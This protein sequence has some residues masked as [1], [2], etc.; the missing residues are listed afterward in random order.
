V[1]SRNGSTLVETLFTLV[2]GT[3]IFSVILSLLWSAARMYKS[4]LEIANGRRAAILF[5]EQLESD[6][7][8]CTVPPGRRKDPVAISPD[9]TRL[10]FFRAD[11]ARSTLQ[12]TI[13]TPVEYGLAGD[14][15]PF[16]PVRNGDVRASV[17]VDHVRYELVR[18]DKEAKRLSWLLKIDATFPTDGRTPL[19]VVR[20]VELV[21]P[22]SAYAE[23]NFVAEVPIGSLVLTD[24]PRS[25]LDLLETAEL[26]PGIVGQLPTAVRATL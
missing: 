24:G 8:A 20:L 1:R 17:H 12:V 18:P 23:V 21:Q 3:L 26:K 9:G 6:L 10:A 25:A 14:G 7:A 11:A 5:F 4:T 22:T 19:R 15:S 16:N 2:L 13:A